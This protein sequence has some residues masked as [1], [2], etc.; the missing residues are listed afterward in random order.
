VNTKRK[1]QGQRRRKDH[2]DPTSVAAN[3]H[4]SQSNIIEEVAIERLKLSAREL[5]N[6]PRRLIEALTKSIQ[7][8]GF[9][10][11]IVADENYIVRAGAARL[12]AAKQYGMRTVPVMRTGNLSEAKLRAFQLSDNKLAELARWNSS[13]L[14][15]ELKELSNLLVLE[16]PSLTIEITGF[17]TAELDRLILDHEN[18]TVDPADIVPDFHPDEI[19]VSQLG[20]LWKLGDHRLICA[21]GRDM[22]VLKQL[23]GSDRAD[24][25]VL[26]PP[27]NLHIKGIGGRG[28]VKH[29]EFAMASGEMSSSQ[30][31]SFLKESLRAAAAFSR[32]GA[33]NYTF[34]DW[35]HLKEL[36]AAGNSAY[37]A[38]INMAIW[39]K[40][41]AGQG[42]LYRSQHEHVA[43][44]RV[45][46]AAHLNN[47][48][49]G[50]HGRSRTNVWHYPGVNS[51][52]PG[53][54][55]N[56][57]DHPTVK[58]VALVCDILRDCTRR[59]DIVLDT[60]CGSGTIVL[61]A[62]RLGRCARAVEIEPRFVDVTIRRFQSFS[63]KDAIHVK[64]G[65]TFDEI[66]K[67]QTR[68]IRR[69]RS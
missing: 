8:F 47:I 26:D 64:T 27:Y 23:M 53:R 41:N 48:Q 39:V 60:F 63:G 10:S 15:L 13:E 6:H 7:T 68:K 62:E 29:K 31:E 22:T 32:P 14:T 51:F 12:A 54:M 25:A 46:D 33:L 36:I 5:R 16:E 45:G 56:L 69:V 43:V 30:F 35:R 67:G 2:N 57:R 4:V 59:N 21:D 9:L 49:L 28:S 1:I 38:F 34:M 55:D 18:E 44:F 37:D 19:V 65:R 58:P 11:V 42:P 24:V 40:N 17:E 61:A 52:G 20:D 66:A 3:Q 50:R